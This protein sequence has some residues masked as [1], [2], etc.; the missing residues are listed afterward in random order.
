MKKLLLFSILFLFLLLTFQNQISS[1]YS[2][3]SSSDLSSQET[4]VVSTSGKQ[5]K[6]NYGSAG[7]YPQYGVLHLDSSYFRLNTGP[8]TSWGT[9]IILLPSFWTNG[10]YKQGA[11]VDASWSITNGNLEL[12][13]VGIISDLSVSI[14]LTLYPPV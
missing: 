9:S 2:M 6:I 3:S 13:L 7:N 10:E 5:L 8:E 11:P 12:F 14:N 1:T 4:W